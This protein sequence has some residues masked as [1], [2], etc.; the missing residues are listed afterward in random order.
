MGGSN[1]ERELKG[2]LQGDESTLF[3]VTK[4]CSPVEKEKYMMI[5]DKPFIVVRAAGSYGVD[6]VA[7]RGDIS[8]LA[9]IKSS[10]SDTLHFS[11][12][13]GKLQKQAMSMKAE[14]EKTKTLPI[15]AFRLKNHRGDAWRIFTLE[16]N[17]LEGRLRVLHKRLPKLE[18]SKGNNLIM[19]WRDGMPLSDFINYLSR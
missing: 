17:G 8:F 11:S 12:I 15:Y 9:E 16:M 7:V 6:L 3:S 1:Y 5:L 2:I 10:T 13:G 14:C 18:L 19:R 4:S